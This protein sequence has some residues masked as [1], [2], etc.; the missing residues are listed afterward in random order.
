MPIISGKSVRRGS[1]SC[2]YA[3]FVVHTHELL[4]AGSTITKRYTS[5]TRGE[6]RREWRVLNLVHR[7]AADLVPHPLSAQLEAIPPAIT[8]SVVPGQPLHGCMSPAQIDALTAAVKRLWTVPQD[9]APR[10]VPATNDLDLARTLTAGPRPAR[11]LTA[12]AYDAATAWWNGP[13]P[14]VLQA[15]PPATV[16]GHRDPN[17]PNYLWDG[18][19]I[20][21]VDFEDAAVSDPATEL[22][23][24]LEH[25]SARQLNTRALCDHFD[26][27]PGRLLAARR[28]WAMYW[29]RLLLPGGPSH[30]HNPA[31]TADAQARRLLHL[32]DNGGTT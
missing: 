4:I 21:I 32:M 17:L 9:A 14:A 18:Q 8:M 1:S 3:A 10:R 24:L 15:D 19:H 6:P 27:D 11:G 20:R 26:V 13:D 30:H 23:I 12:A 16:F 25:L 28:L 5:W 2:A 29:L 22:A 7:H 31:G